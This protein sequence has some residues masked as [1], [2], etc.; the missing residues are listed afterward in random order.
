MAAA[1]KVRAAKPEADEARPA[2][3]GKLAS[4][5][6]V[7]GVRQGSILSRCLKTR[8]AG[9]P[10]MNSPFIQRSSLSAS[11][12]TVVR[13]KNGAKVSEIELVEGRFRW[14]S[15]LPQYFTKAM[16]GCAIAV[17]I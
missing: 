3:M 5:T 14:R 7:E 13:V 12:V 2:F 4:L 11:A 6:T 1:A 8:S 16:F 10:S 17:A 9:A 15:R